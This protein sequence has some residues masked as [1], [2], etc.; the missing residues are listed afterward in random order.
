[1]PRKRRHQAIPAP[2]P[3]GAE[4]GQ[5]VRVHWG[6][7][8]TPAGLNHLDAENLERVRGRK[9]DDGTTGDD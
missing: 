9:D 8:E 5:V 3:N 1:M 2:G 4:E 7:G 6:P